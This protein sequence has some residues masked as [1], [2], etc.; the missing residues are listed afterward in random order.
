MVV[1]VP[2]RRIAW[3]SEA[4][5]KLNFDSNGYAECKKSGRRYKLE[6]KQVVDVTE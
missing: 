6:N 4:G 3:I 5:V 2:A 1:G